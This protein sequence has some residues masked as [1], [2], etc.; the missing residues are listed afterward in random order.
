LIEQKKTTPSERKHVTVVF[1]DL[2]GYT[3]M[4]ERL[5]P[6]EV[7]S[8]LGSV[9]KKIAR[10]VEGY[11]GFI[12]RYIGDSVMAVFGIPRTHEDD[13]V[14][15]VHA[16]LQIH[17][18]VNRMNAWISQKTGC[19][20]CMHTGINTGLVL[21]G[22]VN[23][24]D[25]SHGLTGLDLNIAARLE[26]LAGDDEII[27]GLSTY[28]LTRNMFAFKELKSVK[29][30]GR[31][32]L[33]RIFKVLSK[34]TVVPVAEGPF[35]PKSVFVGREI[36]IQQLKTALDDL[37]NKGAGRVISITG[38]PGIGKSRMVLEYKKQIR[39]MDLLWISSQSSQ[40]GRNMGYGT[41][42]DLLKNFAQI[43]ETDD[44]VKSWEKL[45]TR[46]NQLV[47][48]EVDN[49]LPY[50]A[51]LLSIQVRGGWVATGA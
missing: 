18:A 29:V 48:E 30:K 26:G 16:A 3:A 7:R 31:T 46:L 43:K 45:E 5:D 32:G 51:T 35:V 22:N 33:L 20:I 8:V 39:D 24:E 19:A 34:K 4:T 36:Q 50:L 28:E 21:T 40:F 38:E 13:P 6:E 2:S 27:V 42:L 14:R 23:R 10:I 41:F 15:A 47:P 25:G 9:F 12:E 17:E 37:V 11:D 49:T 1:T 44:D